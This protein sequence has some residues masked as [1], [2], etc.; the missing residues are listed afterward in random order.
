MQKVLNSTLKE[1]SINAQVIMSLEELKLTFEWLWCGCEMHKD[2]NAT[3]GGYQAVMEA[4][5]S[6]GDAP[7]SLANKDN[8]A[9]LEAAIDGLIDKQAIEHAVSPTTGGAIKLGDLPG[10]LFNPKNDKKGH[11]NIFRNYAYKHLDHAV[12]F[13]DASNTRYTLHLHAPAELLVNLDFYISL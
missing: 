13:P 9:I 7:Y 2:R 12:M 6:F 4:W 8:A 3:K 10:A 5:E 1:L 11:Q